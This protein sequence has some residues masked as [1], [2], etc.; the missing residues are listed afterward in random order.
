MPILVAHSTK[1]Y[2]HYIININK[3]HIDETC[4]HI[5]RQSRIR[6]LARRRSNII[7]ST[8]PKFQEWLIR[9]GVVNAI[10]GALPRFY[11][12]K[13]EKLKDDYVK[14]CQLGT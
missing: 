6:V 8:I 10:G 2:K 4:I 1:T 3:L 12:F 11:I 5:G 9:N 7:Y 13:S 14:F